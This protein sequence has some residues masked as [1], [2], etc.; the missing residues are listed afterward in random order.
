VMKINRQENRTARCLG[1]AG[2]GCDQPQLG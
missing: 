1:Y 2:K